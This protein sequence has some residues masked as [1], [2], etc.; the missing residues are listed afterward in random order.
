MDNKSSLGERPPAWVEQGRHCFHLLLPLRSR[1]RNAVKL[2]TLTGT[3]RSCLLSPLYNLR[4]TLCLSPRLYISRFS[5]FLKIVFLFSL[6]TRRSTKVV[7]RRPSH[8]GRRSNTRSRRSSR[9]RLGRQPSRGRSAGIG[10][11]RPR[12]MQERTSAP[13]A[14][15][16]SFILKKRR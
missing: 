8:E 10:R 2:C 14:F 5:P 3:R 4:S 15:F 9:G 12:G 1:R 11:H 13:I 16:L 6:A 7:A